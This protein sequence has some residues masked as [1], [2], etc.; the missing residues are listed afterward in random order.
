MAHASNHNTHKAMAKESPT[1]LKLAW[2]TQTEFQASISYTAR[3]FLK[4]VFVCVR[5][6]ALSC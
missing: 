3:P 5:V 2:V 1:S 4:S 6:C